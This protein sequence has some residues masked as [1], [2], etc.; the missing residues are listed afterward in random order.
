M[1]GVNPHARQEIT[2]WKR[3]ADVATVRTP[4]EI[5]DDWADDVDLDDGRPTNHHAAA[6][7]NAIRNLR[8]VPRAAK[9]VE[10]LEGLLD[11]GES[12]V[13][14]SIRTLDSPRTRSAIS[15]A[16]SPVQAH[17]H[18]LENRLGRAHPEK[19]EFA[20]STMFADPQAREHHENIRKAEGGAYRG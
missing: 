20:G 3:D 5:A 8:G 12:D 13:E 19:R 4:D 17:V 1:V 16:A 6:I 9:H 7:S 14:K 15:K 18:K 10:A 2:I 11:D